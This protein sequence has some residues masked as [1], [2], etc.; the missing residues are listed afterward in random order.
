M[1]WAVCADR[2]CQWD[3]SSPWR[4]FADAHFQ[5]HI[6]ETGHEGVIVQLPDAAPERGDELRPQQAA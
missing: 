4:A 6:L 1:W 5:W 2:H 3:H